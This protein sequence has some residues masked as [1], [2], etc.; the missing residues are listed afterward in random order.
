MTLVQLVNAA[1][2]VLVSAIAFWRGRAPERVGMAIVA[3]A[4]LV[5]PLVER[6]D[7]WLAPQIG[8]LVVD[9]AT[10]A[11]LI[12]LAAAY[13]RYWP[14]WASAFQ[15]VAVL[16]DLAFVIDPRAVYRAYY[17]GNFS[18]GFLLLGAILGGVVIERERPFRRLP[19]RSPRSTP[20]PV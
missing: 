12:S 1:A 5:T 14:I 2:L 13:S 10:M 20:R 11:A 17:F 8:I 18:I 15:A 3:V 4:F 7:S 16:T 19:R 6:R 9:V